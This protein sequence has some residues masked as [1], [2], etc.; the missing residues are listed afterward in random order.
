MSLKIVFTLVVVFAIATTFLAG[1]MVAKER[2]ATNIDQIIKQKVA[3]PDGLGMNELQSLMLNRAEDTLNSSQQCFSMMKIILALIT[4][5]IAVLGTFGVSESYKTRKTRKD[6]ENEYAKL[7]SEVKMEYAL[8]KARA[9]Y[10]Q[11]D[12]LETLKA[13]NELDQEHPEVL[14]LRGAIYVTKDKYD[15]AMECLR[16][17]R[18]NGFKEMERVYFMMGLCFQKQT[19]YSSAIKQYDRALKVQPNHVRSLVNKAYC[20][21]RTKSSP[22]SEMIEILTKAVSIDPS[23]AIA[24]YNLACYYA[25]ISNEPDS[26]RSLNRAIEIDDIFQIKSLWDADFAKVKDT[27]WF[28]DIVLPRNCA[29]HENLSGKI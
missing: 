29:T 3:H 26:K 6:L 7:K 8:L 19:D 12:Y 9:N 21:K 2:M 1:Y 20:V 14:F 25:R 24:H 4:L 10:Y 17:A 5:L 13:L 16:K 15:D 23:I 28:R 27:A 22:E 11:K 18:K